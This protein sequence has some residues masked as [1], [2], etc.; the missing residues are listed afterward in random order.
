MSYKCWSC[1]QNTMVVEP[2][3]K[4]F[5]CTEC[6]ATMSFSEIKNQKEVIEKK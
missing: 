3:G 1:H 6:K 2:E 4:Y 5:Q